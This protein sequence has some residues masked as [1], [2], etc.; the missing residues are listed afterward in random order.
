MWGLEV[1]PCFKPIC[2]SIILL[3]WSLWEKPPKI[4]QIYLHHSNLTHYTSSGL[5]PA[6]L[7]GKRRLAWRSWPPG[8]HGKLGELVIPSSLGFRMLM[9]LS[10]LMNSRNLLQ[11]GQEP[12]FFT[13]KGAWISCFN[14]YFLFST[15]G[16]VEIFKDMINCR[17]KIIT[18]CCWRFNLRRLPGTKRADEPH[19]MR[20]ML[21]KSE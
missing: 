21:K 3:S 5:P 8:Y 1:L 14:L 2:K 11:Q 9:D 17:L 18:C 6:P 13:G 15:A 10:R 19:R 12:F 16:S 7:L 20:W 4:S